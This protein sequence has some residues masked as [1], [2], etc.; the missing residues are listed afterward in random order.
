MHDVG[1]GACLRVVQVKNLPKNASEEHIADFFATWGTV[2]LT[3][4]VFKTEK[5]RVVRKKLKK[6]NDKPPR[7]RTASKCCG[8]K[9]PESDA[10]FAARLAKYNTTC[11]AAT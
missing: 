8:L 11:V 4:T 2:M 9:G 1:R 3:T 7:Q 6:L 5:L 10:D